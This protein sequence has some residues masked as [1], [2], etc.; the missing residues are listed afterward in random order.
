MD[1][2]KLS[3]SKLPQ[4]DSANELGA[5]SSGNET[6][7]DEAMPSNTRVRKR[8]STG[9]LSA[10]DLAPPPPTTTSSN[11]ELI[12]ERLFSVD[13]L[14]L[15]LKDPVHFQQFRNFLNLYRPQSVPTL[16]QYLESHK[17]LTAIRYA[18]ALAD[19]IS[20]HSHRSPSSEA[21]A[22][23]AK[24]ESF[25]RHSI[26]ELVN[27]ALPAY[28]TYRMVNVVTECLVKEITGNNTPLM[29]DLVQG[30][31]E[32]YCLSDPSLPDNPIVFASEEFYNTTQYGQEYIIGKNCR[33]LQGPKTQPQTVKRISEAVSNGREISEIILNYRR[34]GTPFLNLVM[35]APLMDHHGT[36]RYFIGCQVDI[37]HLMAGGRGLESLKQLLNNDTDQFANSM[38]DP[39]ARRPPL[40][41]LRELTTLL[42]DEEM[43]VVK[44]Q[45]ST[46]RNSIESNCSTPVR[47]THTPN[48][49]RVIGMDE[50]TEPSYLPPSQ[51]G[52][53][54]RLPGVYQNYILV[55]PY[56]SLRIIFTSAAL[57]IPGL[58]QSRLMDRIGGPSHVREGLLDAL[59]Q[60]VGVTAK[61]SWLTQSANRSHSQAASHSYANS[62]SS[63]SP[64]REVFEGKPRWIHCTPLIGSD[65]KPGVIMIVMVDKEEITGHLN[66]SST[67]QKRMAL[68]LGDHVHRI[69][70]QDPWPLRAAAVGA[71]SAKFTSA[72]L[73]ADYLRREGHRDGN[74]LQ[75]PSID[76]RKSLTS[77][78]SIKSREDWIRGGQTRSQ[79]GQSRSRAIS[80]TTEVANGN[81]LG[82]GG[83]LYT[84]ST[85]ARSTLAPSRSTST[86]RGLGR[87]L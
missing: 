46:R 4:I 69:D 13:H 3:S 31:A 53:S 68:R 51:F 26:E 55:R 70:G 22:V 72:K 17:A 38:G 85:G 10:Y 11:A 35:M 40:K 32:V 20:L 8:F 50:P 25:S 41:A 52:A 29:R 15:I 14:I 28:I 59:S 66:P 61:I 56:P 64:E 65:S 39:L 2:P 44:H 63:N 33:F 37:S 47:P 49:R 7:D 76:G 12:A 73:Y 74:T 67:A 79:G 27:D 57:R 42:N 48:T 6:V 9:E 19:Q 83:L 21:A 77:E 23:D 86:A 24:F 81:I 43:D 84:P 60:G 71:T 82:S 5:L 36:V 80:T 75:A 1:S 54:G 34:D 62:D 58:S 45:H 16:V 78:R 30:L 87:D 18:N